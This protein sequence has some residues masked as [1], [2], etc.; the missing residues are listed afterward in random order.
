MLNWLALALAA[1]LLGYQTAPAAP[2]LAMSVPRSSRHHGRRAGALFDKL[3]RSTWSDGCEETDD[4]TGLAATCRR[5]SLGANGAY[6]QRLERLC[7]A[8]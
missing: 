1:P 2:T 5:L 4:G 3:T 6:I 8:K 7:R